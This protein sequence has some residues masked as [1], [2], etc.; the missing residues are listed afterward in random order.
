MHEELVSVI[1]PTFNCSRHLSAS[2]DSIL[3]QTYKNVE[4]LI[5]DDHSTEEETL[6]I[7]KRYAEQDSR[8][9][10]L[11]LNTNKG[12]GFARDQSINRARGRYIAFCDSDDRWFPEKLERQIKF[13]NEKQCALTYTSYIL[14]DDN[15]E[16]IGYNK[17]L[18]SLTFGQLK[19]DNKIGCSTAIYDTKLL[20][21]KYHMPF[22]R[23]R[24]DWGLFLSIMRDYGKKAYAIQDPLAYYRVRP[25]S[26][27][28]SKVGL[29]KYNVKI[30]QKVLGFSKLKSWLYFIFLFM[31]THLV[32]ITKRKIQ[33]FLFLHK[34]NKNTHSV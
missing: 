31:P 24:Q 15:D 18:K 23:K 17:A 16:E 34:K 9:D 10:V 32:K 8:V 21:K 13:M 14:C 3:K 1:M 28:S 29:V 12:P 4:L 30:Y 5:T 11:F 7:L 20:G 19:R 2:I 26:V 6:S 25:Q 27:S 33:S 22:I